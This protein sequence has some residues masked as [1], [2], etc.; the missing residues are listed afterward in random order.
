MRLALLSACE[1][2]LP[3]T[4]LPDEVVSLPTRLLQAGVAGVAASLWSV[5]DLSTT[6]L[7][8]RFYFLLWTPL[9][10]WAAAAGL[11]V[12]LFAYRW[13]LSAARSYGDLLDAALPIKF[14]IAGFDRSGQAC[15]DRF[16]HARYR[17]QIEGFLN[18]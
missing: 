4:Q 2:G 18:A 15:F 5:A 9:A 1:T 7:L 10:L 11:S 8:V 13:S 16:P 12:V 14:T 17:K 3:G 6:L